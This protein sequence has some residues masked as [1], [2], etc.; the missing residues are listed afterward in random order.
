[1]AKVQSVKIWKNP[2]KTESRIYAK[3]DDGREGCLY[4]TG[5]ALKKKG[6]ITGDLSAD[7]WQ[8]V[9]RVS[10]ADNK[11]H[12][13][14]ESECAT[15]YNLEALRAQQATEGVA[16]EAIPVE[17]S[18]EQPAAITSFTDAVQHSVGDVIEHGG[19]YY[20]ITSRYADVADR[21]TVD[22]MEFYGFTVQPA[23]PEEIPAQPQPFTGT[24]E[25]RAAAI[26]AFLDEE[27]GKLDD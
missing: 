5:N 4:I 27:L 15:F 6:S 2:T 24:E 10:I 22:Y 17:A 18:E 16:T 20:V 1:M 13:R 14:Y 21:T 23:A 7:D 12:T 25:E 3:M 11:W 19:Q 26:R 9:R 8:E